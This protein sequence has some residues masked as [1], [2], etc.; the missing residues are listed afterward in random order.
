[1]IAAGGVL[2]VARMRNSRWSGQWQAAGHQMARRCRDGQPVS[3]V[4]SHHSSTT[5]RAGDRLGIAL[6]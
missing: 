4:A 5:S 3:Y 6:D 1:M 2:D